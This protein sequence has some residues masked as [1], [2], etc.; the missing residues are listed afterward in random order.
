M[1]NDTIDII[2]AKIVN[3]GIDFVIVGDLETNKFVILNR[4]IETLTNFYQNKLEIG[5]PFFITDVY[6]EL[7]QVDGVVDT[8]SVKITQKT[9]INY[10][11]TR[12]NIDR[13]TSPDGRHINVPD[14]VVM[15]L[16]F[17]ASDIRGD[18][19]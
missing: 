17:P 2:D 7:N 9:G 11:E 10:A 8:V 6:N 1:I 19:K 15:E 4:A 3:F 14:N 18:I 13:A 16:K 12:F 5:E